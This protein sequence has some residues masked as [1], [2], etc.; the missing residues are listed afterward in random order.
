M[1]MPMGD[2]ILM[3]APALSE[4]ILSLL[5]VPVHDTLW[6]NDKMHAIPLLSM[7]VT[8]VPLV[9]SGVNMKER[10]ILGWRRSFLWTQ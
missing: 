3:V 1:H 7:V 6:S 8:D 9:L 4:Y 10:L 5:N 2:W